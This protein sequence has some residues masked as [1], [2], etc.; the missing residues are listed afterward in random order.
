M[1]RIA[2]A[3]IRRVSRMILT[4]LM[5]LQTLTTAIKRDDFAGD[6]AAAGAAI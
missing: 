6:G 3:S 1:V 2:T 5:T 4:T